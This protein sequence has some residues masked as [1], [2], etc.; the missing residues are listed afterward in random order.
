V[1]ILDEHVTNRRPQALPCVF[2]QQS[3]LVLL[4]E[5]SKPWEAVWHLTWLMFDAM[6]FTSQLRNGSL[7]LCGECELKAHQGCHLQG[8]LFSGS[9]QFYFAARHRE[10]RATTAA[11]PW[12]KRVTVSIH[13][14]TVRRAYWRLRADRNRNEVERRLSCANGFASAPLLPFGRRPDVQTCRRYNPF[15]FLRK[16]S[17][18]PSI[19]ARDV[20][21]ACRSSSRAV[22]DATLPPP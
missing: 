5:C 9:A 20:P 7:L 16:A 17:A 12:A 18:W 14:R 8:R 2:A 6:S 22:R 13:A 3:T 10:A 21:Y 19:C 11:E 4:R 1:G 15:G